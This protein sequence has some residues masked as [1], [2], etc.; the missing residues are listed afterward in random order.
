MTLQENLLK[1][2]F[3]KLLTYFEEKIMLKKCDI[4]NLDSLTDMAYKLNNIPESNIAYCYKNYE[5]I[6]QDF[7]SVILSEHN[8]IIGDFNNNNLKGFI[9]FYIDMDKFTVDVC[10]PFITEDFNDTF[11]KLWKFK[12]AYISSEYSFNF[13]VNNKNEN[14]INLLILLNA[15]NN[16]NEYVYQLDISDFNE[17]K[18]SI[19]VNL[20]NSNQYSQFINLHNNMFPDIYVSGNDI[21][22]SLKT[23]RKV[24][25]YEI[26]DQIV[27]YCVVKNNSKNTTIEIL[28]VKEEFRGRQYGKELLNYTIKEESKNSNTFILVVEKKNDIAMKLYKKTGFKLMVENCSYLIN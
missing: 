21:I 23:D 8:L 17:I 7:E 1:E 3:F 20:L 12:D 22:N 13:F 19:T 25:I 18:N 16:G 9:S 15:K 24:Y 14:V 6:K 10:G 28:A 11:Y 2:I 26:K 5:S 4:K 27:G